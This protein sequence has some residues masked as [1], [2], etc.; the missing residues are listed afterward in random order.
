MGE[1]TREQ[2]KRA[3]IAWGNARGTGE[4]VEAVYAAG[5]ADARAAV[6]AETKF[7]REKILC[8]SCGGSG[9]YIKV[10]GRFLGNQCWECR[11]EGRV[12]PSKA[13]RQSLRV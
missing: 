3:Q 5:M 11:G 2:K 6:R 13:S 1:L 7:E 4:G 12:H 9:G 8:G 10:C